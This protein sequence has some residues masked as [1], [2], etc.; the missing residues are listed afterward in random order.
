MKSWLARWNR[1]IPLR[2]AT[3]RVME[4]SLKKVKVKNLKQGG[5]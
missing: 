5:S 2:Y 1:D 4:K 3:K